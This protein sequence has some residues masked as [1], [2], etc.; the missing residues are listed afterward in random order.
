[1]P[2]KT[3][4]QTLLFSATFSKEIKQTVQG[5]LNKNYLLATSNIE[6]YV[7]NDNI[8]Q[9]F[10]YVEEH[11]KIAQLHTLLQECNGTAISKLI[12]YILVFLDRKKAVDDL[13][14][15]MT[16]GNYN[17]AVIHGDKTQ[18]ER[19][20]VIERFKSGKIPILIATDVI[21]R[22]ID[23]PNVSY[24]FNYDTPKNI[25][26]YVHR[27]GRTG[28]CGNTGKAFS[29]IN[30]NSRSIINDLLSL[31]KKQKKEIPDFLEAMLYESKGGYGSKYQSSSNS[32]DQKQ[33]NSTSISNTNTVFQ[34]VNET[35]SWRK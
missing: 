34:S 25:D 33:L 16:R 10:I 30:E 14:K 27:I 6:E 32:N 35:M 31:L 15:I 1:M 26:D 13:Y 3:E 2:I 29:F 28:R 4:R 7:T 18:I 9:H 17:C 20:S 5:A 24:I 22:G 19:N 21:G 8:E 12:N 23:F 11:E